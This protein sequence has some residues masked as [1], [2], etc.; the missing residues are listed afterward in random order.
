MKMKYSIVL[1]T[2]PASFSAL[3]YQGKLDE[4]IRK[5]KEFGYD[6]VE[7]AVRDPRLLDLNSLQQILQN[8]QLS[9]PAIGTGQVFGEENLSFTNPDQKIR[10]KTIERI[11]THIELAE[12]LHA[13]IIIGLVRGKNAG[14]IK[15]EQTE[16]WLVEALQDCAAFRSEVKIAIEP[17]NR[18]ETDILNTVSDSLTF[19]EKLKMENVGLLLDTFHM[20][21]EEPDFVNS[22]IAAGEKIF[23]FHV[24]DSNRWFPGAG[25]INFIPILKTLKDVFYQGYISGEMLPLPDPD[26][27]AKNMLDYFKKIDF[28]FN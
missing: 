10:Q 1:S 28:Q 27:S 17:I 24:A 20:N 18:Y 12:Q 9:V 26:S 5:I 4:N 3:S 23:H 8:Y 2:Q 16:Q 6:G 22:I 14:G 15:K 7:L 19:L 11:K 13:V 25:H 21:I